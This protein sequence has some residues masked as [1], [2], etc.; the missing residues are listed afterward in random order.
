MTTISN[1]PASLPSVTERLRSGHGNIYVTITLDEDGQPFEVFPFLG[2]AGG[3]DY[4]NLEAV[5][6]LVS[7][8]LRAGVEVAEVVDQLSGITCCPSW[9][10]GD[11]I[12][13]APDAIAK[14]LSRLDD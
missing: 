8:L 10:E 14:A 12:R 13:S 2:K 6:R 1:R 4:A 9:D 3:C 7:M 5:G 11:Q